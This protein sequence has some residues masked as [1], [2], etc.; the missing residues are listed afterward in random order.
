ML[1]K[2]KVNTTS[3]LAGDIVSFF[4]Q[5]MKNKNIKTKP[6]RYTL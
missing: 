5:K 1:K 2:E 3:S 6:T 4:F